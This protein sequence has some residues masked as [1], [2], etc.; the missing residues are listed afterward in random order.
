MTQADF[1]VPPVSWAQLHRIATDVRKAFGLQ[2]VPYFP[3]IE[4]IEKVLC[5]QM[6]LLDFQVWSREEMGSAEGYTCPKGTFLAL[7]EDVYLLACHGDGRARFTAAHELGH[8]ILHSNRPLARIQDRT[9]VK[10]FLL[11]EPQAN[12]FAAE[13]LMA[14]E[15]MQPSDTAI[16][17]TARH[18]VSAEAAS[19][20]I[21]CMQKGWK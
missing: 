14:R 10:P 9:T 8:F 15:H 18:G 6:E 7:R 20:R 19:R 1:I 21:G 17:V 4:L 12:R 3:I 16:Q 13:L 11:A 5:G 2:N